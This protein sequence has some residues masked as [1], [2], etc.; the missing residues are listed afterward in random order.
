[1]LAGVCQG[2]FLVPA[3]VA[4]RGASGLAYLSSMGIGV[5]IATLPCVALTIFFTPRSQGGYDWLAIDKKTE[6]HAD[7]TKSAAGHSFVSAMKRALLLPMAVAKE[8]VPWTL[9]GGGLNVLATACIITV[10]IGS[11]LVVTGFRT[12]GSL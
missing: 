8:T 12:L 6:E 9:L 5:A 3:D 7:A 11:L 4:R 2:T 1:M 10:P